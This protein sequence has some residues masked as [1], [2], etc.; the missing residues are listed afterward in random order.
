LATDNKFIR[1]LIENAKQG[2]NAALEQLFQLN[3]GKIFALSFLLTGNKP[4][5]DLITI[6]TFINAWDLTDTID[7]EIAFSEWLKNITVHVALNELKKQEIGK[8]TKEIENDEL[9]KTFASSS[10]TKGYLNLSVTNKF[11]L[12][13]NFIE[14]YS[15]EAI[16][17]LLNIDTTEIAQRITD[18]IKSIIKDSD[19]K[20]SIDTVLEK[21]EDL[22]T[23]II[24]EKN[25]LK[26]ALDK[27]HDM[28]FEE[29][30]KEEKARLKEE[31][32]EHNFSN[33]DLEK[34]KKRKKEKVKIK[35]EKPKLRFNKKYII[36]SLLIATAVAIFYFLSAQVK[37]FVEIETG[38]PELN[39]K[40]ITQTTEFEVGPILRTKEF[41]K[42]VVKIPKAGSIELFEN[43][44]LQRIDNY[45]AKLLNGKLHINTDEAE[46]KIHIDLSSA[47][48]DEL[49]L[50]SDYIVKQNEIGDVEI[51]LSD[52]WLT[53]TSGDTEIIFPGSYNLKISKNGGVGLPYYSTSSPEFISLLEGYVFGNRNTVALNFILDAATEK[54]GITLWNLLRIVKQGQRNA[55]Y[56]KLNEL[57]PHPDLIKKETLLNLDPDFLQVWL[58]DIEWQM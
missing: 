39:G 30:E 48:I 55:V 21:L 51:N 14:N 29:W 58:E 53:V 5:A 1:S 22:P 25:L 40:I 52:G 8:G 38:S 20:L 15:A 28:R 23:E 13:L 7:D 11:I 24:P 56:D 9:T 37:W 35:V 2:N 42:A 54:D 46:E 10:V 27:I 32:L 47:A 6:N 57:Y 16:A 44:S 18:S 43:T 36:F 33:K 49:Y 41:S 31:I 34:E 19:E 4:S 26:Y 45:S 3:L 12:T 50:S 17:T